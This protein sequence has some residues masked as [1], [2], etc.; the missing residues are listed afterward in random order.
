MA[1]TA[2]E[3]AQ[4]RELLAQQAAILSLASNET[5][6]TSKLGATKVNL[7]QLPAASTIS[8]TDI[9]LVRQ[10]TTDKSSAWSVIKTWVLSVVSVGFSSSLSDNGY[11]KFPT[12]LG[13][14]IVQW[15]LFTVTSPGGYVS[16]P[17]AFSNSCWSVQLTDISSTQQQYQSVEVGLLEPS[18]VWVRTNG[19]SE[20]GFYLFAIGK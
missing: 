8:D 11:I 9:M 10:G 17:I 6:I 18:R 12:W 16:F 15:G 13:G 4:T 1:L 2:A 3:E 14:F 7:S 19:A 5:T 20:D